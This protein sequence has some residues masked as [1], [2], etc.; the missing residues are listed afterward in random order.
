MHLPHCIAD[1]VG[2]SESTNSTI[3]DGIGMSAN[4]NR[5]RQKR[6][7]TRARRLVGANE[8]ND[9]YGQGLKETLA[10]V[11]G[12][13]KKATTARGTESRQLCRAM[14]HEEEFRRLDNQ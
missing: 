7:V 12:H 10:A 14:D 1:L 9:E 8:S 6:T 11:K 4:G 13:P 3:A 2:M 5:V